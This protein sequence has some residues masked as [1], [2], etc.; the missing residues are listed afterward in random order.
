MTER[1]PYDPFSNPHPAVAVDVILFT[2][3]DGELRVLLIRRELPPFEDAWALP[4]GFVRADESLDEAAAR[5]LDEEAGVSVRWL[6]QLYTFGAVDRDPAR[7]VISVA[8]FALI[9]ALEL[10]PRAGG[11]ATDVRWC[12]VRRLPKLAFDHKQIVRYAHQRLR[13]KAEY[14]PVAFQLLPKDLTLSELQHVYEV[15]HGKALDKR[16]FRRKVL[17]LEIL[18]PTGESRSEGR[19]RPAALYRFRRDRFRDLGGGVVLEF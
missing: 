6:E 8:Y 15:I 3:A 12:N 14:A 1:V 7:R 9:D 16:N 17:G 4:G 19:G 18:E 11:D 2:I 13:Y 10:S 5:E